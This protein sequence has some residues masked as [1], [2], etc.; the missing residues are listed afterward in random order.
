MYVGEATAAR[1]AFSTLGEADAIPFWSFHVMDGYLYEPVWI[2]P[3][4]ARAHGIA[5]GD[6]VRIFNDR[7]WV[8]GGAYVTERI[9]PGVVYQ[10]HGARLDPIEVG[11]SDRGGANNLIAPSEVAMKNTNA[12]VTSGYL[13]DF[14]KVDV[15][16]LAEQ[17]PEA[18][19]RE[20]N[21]AGVTI[22]N[23]LA[24]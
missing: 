15:F 12:E 22:S 11:A 16:A 4:D 6:V 19:G 2:N 23:W 1:Q 17:Y 7:G 3:V 13:V 20:F 14:E 18:F 9:K 10:D 5:T 24:Q 21:E 8:L